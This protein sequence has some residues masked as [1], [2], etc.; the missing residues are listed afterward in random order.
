IRDAKEKAARTGPAGVQLAWVLNQ[1]APDAR[2]GMLGYSYG[3]RVVSGAAHLLGGG[4]LNGAA[5]PNRDALPDRPVQAVYLAAALDAT[6]LG[7]RQAH[8][9]SLRVID[10]LLS[11]TNRRDP[12]MCLYPI[13]AVRRHPA[14]GYAGPTTLSREYAS[15]VR[16]RNLAGSVGRTHD[17]CEYMMAPGVMSAAWRRLT[18]ADRPAAPQRL[19]EVQP[20]NATD[21]TGAKLAT[22]P[23]Q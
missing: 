11:S 12:A 22:R 4:R 6:W 23:A 5:L 8:G 10:S 13:I 16:L 9:C 21:K 19:V 17:M 14:V 18:F 2:L 20:A 15:K 7:P 1:V 3:A